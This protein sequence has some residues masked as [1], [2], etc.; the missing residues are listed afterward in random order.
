ML[1]EIKHPL[2]QH[3]LSILREKDTS[4]SDFR[5]HSD[6][7]TELLLVEATKDL[8]T[9]SYE[10]ETPLTQ[11]TGQSLSEN[12]VFVSILR[13][14]VA[15]LFGA[16]KLFPAAQVGFVGLERN[17]ETAIAHEYYWKL[18][19]LKKGMRVILTDPMLATGGSL[20][21]VLSRII[22]E[23]R[24]VKVKVVSVIAAPEGVERLEKAF[25]DLEIYTGA[26]DEKLNDKAYIVPG[27]GD[28]GDRYFGT[29]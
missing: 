12:V 14:G 17:E 22:K 18:P 3:S 9:D 11:T 24:G 10:L 13:A 25:P 29:E 1:I 26:L 15:M 28:Y 21:H 4:L 6:K 5:Y 19:E 23:G 2:I 7:L 8:R 27:L 20:H 16:I